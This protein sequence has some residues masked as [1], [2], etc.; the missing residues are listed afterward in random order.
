MSV[1]IADDQD[2]SII[3]TGTWH[4][5]TNVTGTEVTNS[6]LTYSNQLNATAV[7]KFQGMVLLQTDRPRRPHICVT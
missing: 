7:Y 6:S 5:L 4:S 3:Y 2:P 1:Q